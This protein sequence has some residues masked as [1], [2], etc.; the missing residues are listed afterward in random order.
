MKKASK[1]SACTIV[2]ILTLSR[3]FS[4]ALPSLALKMIGSGSEGWRSGKGSLGEDDT[5]SEEGESFDFTG[6]HVSREY[7]P[8]D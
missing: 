8:L 6:M 7:M 1:S 3:R 4:P 5:V 2:E